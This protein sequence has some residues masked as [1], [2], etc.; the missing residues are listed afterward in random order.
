MNW[1]SESSYDTKVD[2]V[3]VILVGVTIALVLA[4]GF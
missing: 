4:L 3:V 2:V 1:W